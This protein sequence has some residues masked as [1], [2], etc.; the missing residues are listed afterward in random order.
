MKFGSITTIL[1]IVLLFV[2]PQS[3]HQYT[4]PC[5]SSAA[6]GC[7]SNPASVSRIVGGESANTNTW[8]W[9][10][11]ISISSSN[12]CG[13]AVLSSSWII[14]AAHCVSG[15]LPSQV[16]VFAG[17]TTRYSDQSRVASSVLV[18]P[19]YNRE[20]FENDIALIQLTTPL[21][22]TSSIKSICVPSVSSATLAAGEWP[23]AGLYVC[24]ITILDIFR[25]PILTL[26]R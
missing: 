6:C 14:T 12:L 17:S 10:V 3:S 24:S 26:T 25:E 11:S 2:I 18:H 15:A 1:S 16:V 20:T 8:G 13:G 4:Y 22:M 19:G 21:T 9:A 5:N 23:S 7:S